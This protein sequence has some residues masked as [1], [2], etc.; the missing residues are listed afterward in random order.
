MAQS[1]IIVIDPGHGGNLDVGGSSHNNAKSPSGVLEKNI[2]LRL[3]FLV[4]DQLR[5][6]AAANGVDL[7][8]ILTRETDVNL[9]L[10]NRA[11][12][13]KASQA[14]LFLSI[15]CNAFD[16]KARGTETL[17]SP[18]SDGN[19]NRSAEADYAKKVLN[20]VVKAIKKHD[21]G[22]KS[23]GVKDQR[24]GVLRE[25]SL[26]NKTRG[27]LLEVEFIDNPQIDQLLNIGPNAPEVRRDIAA[28]IA[29]AMLAVL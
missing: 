8:V 21:S 25:S 20:A 11:K 6:L 17:V 19:S 7:N 5:Q 13:A 15:H 18:A 16:G 28:G 29:G 26:G 23:R 1:K 2:T 10:A 12:I 24:L 22:A 14:D 4:R 3:A 9:P 27:C